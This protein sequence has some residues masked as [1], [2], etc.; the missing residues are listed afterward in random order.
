MTVLKETYQYTKQGRPYEEMACLAQNPLGVLPDN[1]L[2]PT[3]KELHSNF[4][5]EILM[6]LLSSILAYYKKKKKKKIKSRPP[7]GAR[8]SFLLV[9]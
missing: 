6:N 2:F 4:T 1:N 5:F 7:K 3:S 8:A 9:N